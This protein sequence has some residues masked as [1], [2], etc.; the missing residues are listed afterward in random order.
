MA[1]VALDDLQLFSGEKTVII[2]CFHSDHETMVGK[3]DV[4][5]ISDGMNVKVFHWHGDLDQTG[6]DGYKTA[7]RNVLLKLLRE[8]GAIFMTSHTAGSSLIEEAMEDYGSLLPKSLCLSTSKIV[9]RPNCYQTTRK[10]YVTP[11]LD[12][13]SLSLIQIVTT[14]IRGRPSR[15]CRTPASLL[16][17]SPWLSASNLQAKQHRL[18]AAKRA[19]SPREQDVPPSKR[20]KTSLSANTKNRDKI[21]K[22]MVD[23]FTTSGQY[24][25]TYHTIQHV[26]SALSWTRLPMS[27]MTT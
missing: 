4:V 19:T 11:E 5:V 12:D 3:W 9:I 24:C 10:F 14:A 26:P 13:K 18:H 1:Q 2:P 22:A 17:K 6:K 21:V 27:E 15:P 25:D 23:Y 7:E 20:R 8:A 16:P